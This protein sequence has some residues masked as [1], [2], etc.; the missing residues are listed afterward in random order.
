LGG[1]F[2]IQWMALGIWLVPLTSLLEAHGLQGLRPFAYAASAIAAMTSPLFFGAMADRHVP[3]VIV[4]RRLALA[5]CA[6]TLLVSYAVDHVWPPLIILLVIQ[7]LALC[8]APVTSISTSIVFA[9]LRDP[10]REFGPIRAMATFGWMCGCWV[11][12]L[13]NADASTRSCYAGAATWIGLLAFTYLLPE[14]APP[15]SAGKITLR[16]RMGWDALVLLKNRDT[17]VVFIAA[18]LYN[19]PLSA[20][21]PF[22]PPHLTKL[23][24]EHTSAWMSLGQV[25]EMFAMFGLAG[26]LTRW[27]LKWVFAAG[28]S[29]GVL[30]YLFCALDTKWMVLLGVSLHGLSYTLFYITAQIYLEQRI[31]PAWRTRAQAL[32]TLMNA[33]IGNLAGYLGV[34]LWFQF[35]TASNTT[36]WPVFWAG[37]CACVVAV[38]V[39]FLAAYH[40][41]GGSRPASVSSGLDNRS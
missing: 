7:C 13:L 20:F 24:L 4:L 16:E 18:A 35:C 6:L 12:S 32:F 1:L 30:R 39:W 9:Q 3:P 40:G 8:T 21:Y 25:S 26:L 15:T 23:G 41:R 2:L 19:I 28:L 38:M 27:R 31:D 10:K 29:F 5:S 36:R 11:V 17:L 14:V 37:M 22:T 34:G 33:G